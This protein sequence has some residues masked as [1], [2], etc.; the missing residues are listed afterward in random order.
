MSLVQQAVVAAT[1]IQAVNLQSDPAE[2]VAGPIEDAIAGAFGPG[3][4]NEAP[5]L[6]EFM[7]VEPNNIY[8]VSVMVQEKTGGSLAVAENL[9]NGVSQLV[10]EA[11]ERAV[12]DLLTADK[13]VVEVDDGLPQPMELIWSQRAE[14]SAAKAVSATL[15]FYVQAGVVP[16]RVRQSMHGQGLKDVNTLSVV[17]MILEILAQAE[18]LGSMVY[19]LLEGTVTLDEV[20]S[21][22]FTLRNL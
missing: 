15:P 5:R 12:I 16:D 19:K 3:F 1:A 20:Q 18:T 8:K 2:T 14:A 22:L 13:A 9:F 21:D 7:R 4:A 11:Q 17:N 6:T 10:D